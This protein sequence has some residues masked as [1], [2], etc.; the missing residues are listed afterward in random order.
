MGLRSSTP[1]AVVLTLGDELIFPENG[2]LR[3][4]YIQNVIKSSLM[5][6][7]QTIKNKIQI[8]MEF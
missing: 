2:N 8:M 4:K 6:T 5:L 3:L 1:D 7:I